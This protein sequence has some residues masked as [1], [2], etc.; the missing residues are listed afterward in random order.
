MSL[1]GLDIS[2]LGKGGFRDHDFFSQNGVLCEQFT[3]FFPQTD[4]K[5]GGGVNPKNLL[6]IVQTIP[7]FPLE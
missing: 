5:G 4:L 2:D 6:V 1:V 7:G 3:P